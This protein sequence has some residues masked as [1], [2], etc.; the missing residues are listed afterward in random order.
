MAEDRFQRPYRASE[1][2]VRTPGKNT[3]SDPLA[4]LARLIGQTDPFG[5]YG[6]DSARRA[7]AP[8]PAERSDW[9]REPY[10]P[11]S[12]ADP[13][14]PQRLDHDQQLQHRLDGDE[15]YYSARPA[16][17][18]PRQTYG[19]TPPAADDDLYHADHEGRDYQSG[20]TDYQHDAYAQGAAQ[21]P[22]E[23]YYEDEP[24]PRRRLGVIAIAGVCA[25][26]V[27]G[28]AGA[29]GYRA[30]F[31]SSA[32]TQPPPVIK[33][34]T[35]PNKIV[36]ATI[37]KDAQSNKL[38]TERVNERG[39]SEK[40]V[41]R[42]EQ[43]V[44]SAAVGA[45]QMAPQ[46]TLGSGVVGSEPKKV[47]TIA[48]HPD[49]SIV[50]DATPSSP[51]PLAAPARPAAAAARTPP[52]SAPPTQPAPPA[53]VADNASADAEQDS[54]SAP[55]ARS[56]APSRQAAPASGSSPLSLSPDAAPARAAARAPA[57]AAPA[58]A[59]TAAVA[60]PAQMAPA[61]A[62]AASGNAGGPG[63]Y[64]Q[65][66]SQRSEAEAQ[67]AFRSLQAKYPDQLG[68]RQ[69]MIYKVDLGSKGTY[70]RAMVGPFTNASEAGDLCSSLKA[71]GGQCLIQKN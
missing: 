46:S 66:S 45:S 37:G 6:R 5:E 53:R 35:G 8:Q 31:G 65:V 58:P 39:Q 9:G 34:D 11:H 52:P 36:P 63:S 23:E 71:A 70:Y 54:A 15:E 38:I 3:G 26:A 59:R 16:D 18:Y 10:V 33:A 40:L 2:P 62:P 64:V 19:G 30:L 4:E 69:P 51:V 42:E 60:A 56:A 27:I 13:R 28:T 7:H 14:S 24:P 25:L 55:A 20:Q 68:G 32:S 41:S 61:P 29:Y 43:P 17:Q 48:I 1:P 50:A 49:Q 44:P 57:P 22:E 21:F 12:G 67:A 47:R